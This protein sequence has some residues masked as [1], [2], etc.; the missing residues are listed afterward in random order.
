M[1][2]TSHLPPTVFPPRTG[3]EIYDVK[4]FPEGPVE[5]LVGEVLTLNCTAMVEFNA[6]V[7]IQWSYP[8]KQ[9]TQRVF[10]TKSQTLR[11]AA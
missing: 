5:L 4:L 11:L 3:S 1:L 10:S 6:G 7:D 9:V 8:G 2:S